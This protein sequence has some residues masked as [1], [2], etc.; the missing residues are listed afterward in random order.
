MLSALGVPAAEEQLF[1]ALLRRSS[2]TV[3]ELAAET[4]RTVA[5]CGQIISRLEASGLVNRLPNAQG[6]FAAVPPDVAFRGLISSQQAALHRAEA[7]VVSLTHEYRAALGPPPLTEAV[8]VLIGA[9]TTQQRARQLHQ[10][11]SDEILELLKTPLSSHHPAGGES[12]DRI[13]GPDQHRP[14]LRYRTVIE[15]TALELRQLRNKTGQAGGTS[16]T[17]EDLR[18]AN[19]VPATMVLF[20]GTSALVSIAGSAAGALLVHRSALLDALRALFELIW[21]NA[22]PLQ[23]SPTN[24]TLLST[25]EIQVLTLLVGGLTD[26]AIAHQLGISERSVQRYVRILMDLASAR[27]RLQLGWHASSK[28]WLTGPAADR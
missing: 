6:S 17:E 15:A 2:A 1:R 16:A 18:I 25:A 4:G 12:L 3:A 10:H 14:G 11:A 27:S 9:V 26:R 7:E 20:D 8:E 19:A 23:R 24:D 21:S 28:G 5:E 13:C 22:T